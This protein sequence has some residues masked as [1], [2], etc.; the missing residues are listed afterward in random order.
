MKTDAEPKTGF[1]LGVILGAT[2]GTVATL[3]ATRSSKSSTS[4]TSWLG[5]IEEGVRELS[6]KYPA[7]SAT[8]K[9]LAE[10]VWNQV[11]HAAKPTAKKPSKKKPTPKTFHKS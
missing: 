5:E 3:V 1:T 9:S 7:Q 8:L 10:Q 6:S 4:T 2:L 11:T